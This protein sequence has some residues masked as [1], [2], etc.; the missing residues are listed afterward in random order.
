M[1]EG[2]LTVEG[3]TRGG[4][5]EEILHKPPI[6]A[7]RGNPALPAEWDRIANR[8]L[9]KDRELRYQTAGELR[10]DLK[11]LRRDTESGRFA[12]ASTATGVASGATGAAP[13]D[14]KVSG[15]TRKSAIYQLARERRKWIALAAA[16]LIGI[17]GWAFYRT[18]GGHALCAKD[19][20]L[21]ADFLN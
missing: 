14:V 3:N 9:E 19:T 20:L 10:A 17:G 13:A 1:M 8:S 4:L 16:L 12:A 21:L 2:I 18:R 11:R 5:L 15:E 7:T 6:P